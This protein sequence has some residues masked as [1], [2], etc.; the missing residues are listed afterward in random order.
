MR[1]IIFEF[2]NFQIFKSSIVFILFI[3]FLFSCNTKPQPLVIGKDECY[4]C[5]MPVADTKFGAEIITEKGKLYKFD[6]TGCLINYLKIG[7]GANEKIKNLLNVDY[8]SN[9]NFLNVNTSVFLVSEK[10]HTPMNS[11]IAGFSSRIKAEIFL[12]DFPGE[13]LT[14]QQL[15]SKLK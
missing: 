9:Q 10:F 7:L 12:K 14:W 5:K 8:T 6:D 13:I 2:S 11:G 4:F 15:Q 1:K 3:P